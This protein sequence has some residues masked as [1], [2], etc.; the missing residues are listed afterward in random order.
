MENYEIK[1]YTFE[2]KFVVNV[3]WLV[4]RVHS[5]TAAVSSVILF[6]QL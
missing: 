5:R 1:T 6:A 4:V 3:S 2:F